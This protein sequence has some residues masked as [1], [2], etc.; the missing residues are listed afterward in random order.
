MKA[1][2]TF[3]LPG[4]NALAEAIR[5]GLGGEEGEFTMKEFPDGETYLR[6]LSDVKSRKIV[7]VCN[8][9][10][11][12]E[13]ILALV[14]MCRKL[15]ELGADSVC[16]VAPYLSYMRQDKEFNEGEVVSAVYF[17]ELL[18]KYVDRLITVDP[19]LHRI[20]KLEEVFKIPCVTVHAAGL[21]ALW[22]KTNVKDALL[23]GP[24]SESDQWI[25]GITDNI[26]VPYVVLSKERT[27]AKDVSVS[28]PL[29]E[30]YKDL[31]PVLVDDIISTAGTMVATVQRLK[32]LGMKPP[33]C[34]GIHA[35]FSGDA[36]EKLQAA[37]V[38]KII[39]CDSI[40]HQSN[41]ITILP[42]LVEAVQGSLG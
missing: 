42:L 34:I 9:D 3:A 40:T 39:S 41:G 36:Y 21:I 33:V 13:K 5:K 24:D 1:I 29:V 8:L 20:R 30:K 18:G 4:N 11:P 32:E 15:K 17:A 6:I 28:V 25:K 22:I 31:T 23:I 26:D 10:H 16:L 38:Q 7:L 14:F 2:M 35:V 37:G 19:H 12:N 27:S